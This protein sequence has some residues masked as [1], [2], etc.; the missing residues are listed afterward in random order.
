M[1]VCAPW[2][3]ETFGCLADGVVSSVSVLSL[4][5]LYSLSLF[6]LYSISIELRERARHDSLRT[7]GRRDLRL[8]R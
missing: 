4:F 6:S 1:I 2:A 3:A 5:Y 7:L 8:S